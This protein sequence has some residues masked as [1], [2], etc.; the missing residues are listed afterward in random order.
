VRLI[1]RAAL[2]YALVSLVFCSVSRA[3][4]PTA[5]N[6]LEIAN[7]KILC[8]NLGQTCANLDRPIGNTPVHRIVIKNRKTGSEQEIFL[9]LEGENPGGSI[10]DRAALSMIEDA[11][12]AGRLQPGGTIVEA[13]SGN[14]GIGVALVAKQRGYKCVIFM[15]AK[16]KGEKETI[17]KALGAEVV[18]TPDGVPPNDPL[19]K[20]AL[21]AEHAQAT[22][23]S[24][25]LDQYNNP[26]NPKAH[27]LSTGPELYEQLN[28][29]VDAVFIGMGTG[30]TIT[31]IGRYLKKVSPNTMIVGVE[32]VGSIYQRYKETGEVPTPQ[33]YKVEG[34]GQTSIPSVVDLSVVDKILQVNDRAAF[35]QTIELLADRDVFAG[36]SSG[37]ALAA[38]IEYLH[39]NPKLKRAAVIMPDSG[40]RYVSKIFNEKWMKKV[41]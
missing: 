17:L 29:Q 31:G 41:Q 32:P 39:E 13:T 35:A 40:N 5:C 3:N 19:S 10:K 2:G 1:I 24:V 22:P 34:I 23:N 15:E 25:F 36:G 18:I 38:C 28:R 33:K 9:K 14:T 7:A 21:A 27:E 30:G 12:R 6:A 16:N 4:S 26:A 37:A 11:E 8:K 20:S